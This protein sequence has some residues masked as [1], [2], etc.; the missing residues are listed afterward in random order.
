VLPNNSRSSP[1][2]ELGIKIDVFN[3]TDAKDRHK[4][5]RRVTVSGNLAMINPAFDG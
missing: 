4:R 2:A 3:V 1:A 5:S